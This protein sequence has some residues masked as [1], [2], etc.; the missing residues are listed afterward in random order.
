MRVVGI[1]LCAGSAERMGFDKL[2]KSIGGKTAIQRSAQ[3]LIRGGVD[4]LICVVSESTKQEA[5]K[6]Q[7]NVSIVDGGK[8]RQESVKNGLAAA[9]GDIAVIHDAARCFVKPALVKATIDS[10]IRYGSGVAALPVT[11]TI[12]REGDKP[13]P[14]K[15]DGL[16]RMQTPQSFNLEK[17]RAAYK[18][19]IR[20]TDDATLYLAAGQKVYFVVGSED[21]RKLTTL[22]DWDWAKAKY[23][24]YGTGFDT[25]ALVENRPLIIGGVNI[26]FAKGLMGHSDADVLLHAIMDAMLGACALGDIGSNFPDNDAAYENADSRELLVR[27]VRMVQQHDKSIQNVDATVIC[28]EPKLAPYIM[29]MRQNIAKDCGL[30]LDRVS[31]KATT[32]EKM[33]DEGKGLCISAQ[34]V[35]SVT[36][37]A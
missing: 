32:T 22:A 37:R 23:S 3:A 14:V 15:R 16:W 36:D 27:C 20:A 4:E 30:P 24:R 13:E 2:T 26:P 12:L 7:G 31:V 6:L 9:S 33:N 19:S 17:I 29:D 35:V 10:A 25:H 21:N 1:L 28:Q 11:D 5:K 8:T 34:A 18:N